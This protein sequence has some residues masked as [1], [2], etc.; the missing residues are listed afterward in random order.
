MMTE[1]EQLLRTFSKTAH[2]DPPPS[3]PSQRGCFVLRLEDLI[4]GHLELENDVWQFSYSEAFQQQTR[5]AVMSGFPHLDRVYRS[6]VLW[7]FFQI[8]IPG[9]GQPAIREILERENIDRHNEFELLKRFGERTIANPFTLL[10]Q[11]DQF[12]AA[13]DRND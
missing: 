11:L 12:H 7:P 2:L 4:I 6:R 5:Y 3:F 1:L 13:S 8:R 9:L 10:L